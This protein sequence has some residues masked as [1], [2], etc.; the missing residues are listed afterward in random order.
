MVYI[1]EIKLKERGG[2]RSYP[3]PH[4]CCVKDGPGPL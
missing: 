3:C 4:T 1:L 2:E